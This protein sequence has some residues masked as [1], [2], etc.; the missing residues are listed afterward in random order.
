MNGILNI[1]ARKS[2]KRKNSEPKLGEIYDT[3]RYLQEMKEFRKLYKKVRPAT[4]IR[5][6]C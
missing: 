2:F 4:P 6:I 3:P 1:V 5:N